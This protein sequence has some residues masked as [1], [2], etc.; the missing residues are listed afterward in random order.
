MIYYIDYTYLS[1]SINDLTVIINSIVADRL[2]EYALDGGI[3]GID[4]VTLSELDDH[5]GFAYRCA[6]PI[7]ILSKMTYSKHKPTER[8]P[9]TAIF[10]RFMGLLLGI[11]KVTGKD[12]EVGMRDYELVPQALKICIALRAPTR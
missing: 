1:S 3:V 8:A 5:R 11:V 6:V 9:R 4:K 10:L 7:S 2:A 12:A